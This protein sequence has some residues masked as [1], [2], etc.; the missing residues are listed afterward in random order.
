MERLP[1][2]END[3]KAEADKRNYV[4]STRNCMI[5]VLCHRDGKD[6]F[7]PV[8]SKQCLD[9]L[10]NPVVRK[11]FATGSNVGQKRGRDTEKSDLTPDQKK[12]K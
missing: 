1:P 4:V 8:N 3:I 6:V 2:V 12:T 5:S 9:N 11:R 7:V 10:S